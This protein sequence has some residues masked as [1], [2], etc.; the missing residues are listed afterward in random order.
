MK[1]ISLNFGV[2]KETIK[3]LATYG[4]LK[5][6]KDTITPNFV[7]KVKSNP[8]LYK[9]YFLYKNFEQCKPFNKIILAERFISQNLKILNDI[10]WDKIVEANKNLKKEY[11]NE[12]HT[13]SSSEEK[14]V[15]YEAINTLI[16]S[17]TSTFYENIEKEQEAYE[18]ITNFLTRKDIKESKEKSEYPEFFNLDFF[19]KVAVNNFNKRYDHLNEEEKNI[20]KVLISEGDV[21]KEYLDKLK[22]E[23]EEIITSLIKE[24][25]D[26]TKVKLLNEIKIKLNCINNYSD[27]ENFFELLN[28]KEKLQEI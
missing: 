3:K 10:T 12:I 7:N 23:N 9:Q 27:D 14:G 5:E 25:K 4:I 6:N 18:C 1:D 17:K 26:E 8:I 24:E 22:N 19:T 16:E 2:L 13:E 21:K 28:L 11:L 20:F 15:I